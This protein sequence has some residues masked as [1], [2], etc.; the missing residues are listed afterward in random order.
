MNSAAPPPA[1]KNT[2]RRWPQFRL[3]TL[4][5]AVVPVAVLAAW[6]G[7]R[8]RNR[9]LVRIEVTAEG[10]V[11]LLRGLPAEEWKTALKRQ[12]AYPQSIDGRHDWTA[13]I[14]IDPE[15]PCGDVKRAIR[16]CHDFD[17]E[18]FVLCCAGEEMATV[19]PPLLP[20]EG[21]PENCPNPPLVVGLAAAPDGSLARV[22]LAERA[23]GDLTALRQCL[24]ENFGE[25]SRYESVRRTLC[26]VLACDDALRFGHAV[27][28]Y[29]AVSRCLACDG[30]PACL[31]RDVRFSPLTDAERKLE[32]FDWWP[33]WQQGAGAAASAVRRGHSSPDASVRAELG[34][35]RT[36]LAG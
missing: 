28:A 24:V 32:G 27:E 12:P 30:K 16:A 9:N 26:V 18:R 13:R 11:L 7:D 14:A 23:M 2:G 21:R 6:A 3:R 29:E 20:S 19:L 4:L 8:V 22:A 36:S 33:H 35:V 15:A 17:I 5:L 25:G 10:E 31:I 1:G 34:G